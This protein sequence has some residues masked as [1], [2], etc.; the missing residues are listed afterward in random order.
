LD[1]IPFKK[2]KLIILSQMV[3][4]LTLK[5]DKALP[6]FFQLIR[7]Q[8]ETLFNE[9]PSHYSFPSSPMGGWIINPIYF[10]GFK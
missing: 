1:L 4:S 9:K 7:V 8:N 10:P 2:L 3:N 5:G 6:F